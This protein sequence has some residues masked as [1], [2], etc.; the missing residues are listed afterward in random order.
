MPAGHTAVDIQHFP[1]EFH[2]L[3]FPANSALLSLSRHPANRATPGRAL[4]FR[5]GE[6][7]VERW[8]PFIPYTVG[9]VELLVYPTG[10]L[11]AGE[12]ELANKQPVC[13]AHLRPVQ[14][15]SGSP[16]PGFFPGLSFGPCF[17]PP[18]P[19]S[20][21]LLFSLSLCSAGCG[22]FTP[23]G[24]LFIGHSCTWLG[25]T[26]VSKTWTRPNQFPAIL[27]QRHAAVT[28]NP[29]LLDILLIEEKESLVERRSV[30]LRI[31][32]QRAP[33]FLSPLSTGPASP[34]AGRKFSAIT[35]DS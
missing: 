33:S 17:R 35:V 13:Q 14:P 10:S 4:N 7:S 26:I 19:R 24:S 16:S 20:G 31:N 18:S 11:L 27:T 9:Q 29:L 30:Q 32:V 28:K 22:S 5:R 15:T 1:I 3:C 34:K 8:L 23:L 2:H 12:G 6:P 25:H 21:S